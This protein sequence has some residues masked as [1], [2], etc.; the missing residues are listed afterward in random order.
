MQHYISLPQVSNAWLK[1][2]AGFE[3]Q[4][5]FP[6]SLGAVDGKHVVIKPPPGAGSN[7]YNYKHTHT[8]SGANGNIVTSRISLKFHVDF[9][10]ETEFRFEFL[11]I[12]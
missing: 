9:S 12:K 11:I 1:I 6:N 8:F 5:N 4:W 7:Y 2:V 3:N 10:V